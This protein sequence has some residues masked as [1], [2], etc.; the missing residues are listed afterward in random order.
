MA[1]AIASTLARPLRALWD[2][3]VVGGL[4]DGQLLDRFTTGPSE[5]I[6][7]AFQALVERHG[8]MV[9]RVCRRVLDDPNDADGAFQATFLVLLRRARS[10]RNRGS[11]ASWLHGVAM[12]IAARARVESARRR[13][14]EARGVRPSVGSDNDTDRQDSESLIHEELHRLPEKYRA[15]IVLCYLEGLT[16]EGAADQLGWP[17]GTVR[18]R[19]SRARDLLRT[20]LT[21]R[22]VTATAALA[23]VESL[24]QPARA[25]VP[26][27]LRDATIQSVV[28]VATGRAIASVASA[29]VAIWVEGTSRIV[30]LSSWKMAAG[31]LLLIGTLGTGL[32][33]VIGG[34]APSPQQPQIEPTPP[35]TA[36][37]ANRREM[38]Q[39]KGTWA[40]MQRIENRMIGGVPQPPKPYK[41]IWSID[42]DTITATGEDGF[43]EHTYRFTVD[44]NRAPKT[45]D[46][47]LL[48][49]DLNS[50]GIY[51]VEGDTLTVCEGFEQRPTEFQGGPTQFQM[52][53]QR[54]SR[55]PAALAPEYPNAS[56][57]YWAVEPSGGS[58]SIGS[59][60]I[61]AIKRK[62]PQ[63][64]MVVTMAYNAKNNGREPGPEYRPVAFDDKKTRYLLESDGG[65]SSSTVQ[66]PG[67][68]LALIEYRLDPNALPFDRVKNLGIEMVSREV[69]QAEADAAMAEAFEEARSARIELLPHAEIGKPYEFALTSEDGKP[70]RSD[71]LKGKVV[72]ID[73]WASWNGTCTEKMPRL[74]TLY[75]RRRGD[76]FEVI[77]L[78]FDR[79]AS[80]KR[81]VKAQALD[82]PQ[83]YVPSDDRTRRLWQE[84]PGFP[85]YPRLLLI[86]RQGIL[87]WDD[88]RPEELDQ[89]INALLDAPRPGNQAN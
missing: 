10:V 7:P 54:E 53:F 69:L 85:S 8:P 57:C 81:L 56:G 22:G 25:A 11:V 32:G 39:L 49:I 51:K 19:L 5:S 12:R 21:R 29:H 41:L 33:L 70:L 80:G 31:L 35:P 65:R 23:A 27:V 60:A 67:I 76:G 86:D 40:S 45:I 58:T 20:R 87:R 52:V 46:L 61:H 17:V 15:P 89:R 73:C 47:T 59:G 66:F 43:A 26:A 37:E 6:E 2:L 77:G 42:R 4:S 18:G 14:I 63:G 24:T 88:G 74:K 71:S 36:R 64:A 82:W 9:L 83:I 38:L 62:D 72:L 75:Q 3:G 34:S 44:P 13:R 30:A 28:Q 78:N 55:A 79:D 1:G 50:L 48:N 68:I 84:G 16:H